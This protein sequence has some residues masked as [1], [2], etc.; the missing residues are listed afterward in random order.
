DDILNIAL[1]HPM[2]PELRDAFEYIN[3][4]MGGFRVKNGRVDL[5]DIPPVHIAGLTIS[6]AQLRLNEEIQSHYQHA[7]V[8]LNYRERLKNKVELTGN[9]QVPVIPV[10]GKIRLYEVLAK[11]KIRPDANLFMSYVVRN[12][13]QLPIDLH[14][15]M[16]LGD[17]CQN[18]VM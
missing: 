5:P 10:D 6:D 3:A 11:A 15:L 1:F 14:R 12:C 4:T 2:R 17:M 7:A 9:V 8:F 18:I 16:N 13:C